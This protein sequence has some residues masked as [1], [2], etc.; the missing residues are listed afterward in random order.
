MFLRFRF[1]RMWIGS[2]E[3][4]SSS[5]PSGKSMLSSA[6]GLERLCVVTTEMGWGE[7]VNQ[8][9]RLPLMADKRLSFKI[10]VP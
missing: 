1:L 8:P 9:V 5:S 10:I 6:N 3:F 2:E 4:S 7:L